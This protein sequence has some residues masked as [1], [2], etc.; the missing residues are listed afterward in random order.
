MLCSVFPHLFELFL[1]SPP[2]VL[3]PLF[4]SL[5]LHSLVSGWKVQWG[6]GIPEG[7][8]EGG[9]W[10]LPLTRACVCVCVCVLVCVCAKRGLLISHSD[11]SAVAGG[12]S[13][14]WSPLR[15]G[16]MSKMS[17]E[18]DIFK[19]VSILKGHCVVFGEQIQTQ[20]FHV[21]NTNEVIISKIR[22]II[23]FHN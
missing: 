15:V 5:S 2:L 19:R 9:R 22:H 3:S 17:P 16:E 1:H 14:K 20:N 13:V 7:Q 8:G 12:C 18:W 6:C 11:L 10:G 23:C 21:H 4:P